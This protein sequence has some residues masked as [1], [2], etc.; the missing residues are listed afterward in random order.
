MMGR[1]TIHIV[2]RPLIATF[3]R[4]SNQV[5]SAREIQPDLVFIICGIK[6]SPVIRE[7]IYT[8]LYPMADRLLSKGYLDT[9]ACQYRPILND[10][11]TDQWATQ[12][13]HHVQRLLQQE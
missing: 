5:L 8:E 11:M 9:L 2:S 6:E 4:N 3:F 10:R 7:A 12:G 13:P 1:R